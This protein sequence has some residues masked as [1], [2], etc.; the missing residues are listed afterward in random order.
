MK[1]KNY[2]FNCVRFRSSKYYSQVYIRVWFF[3]RRRAHHTYCLV[4]AWWFSRRQKNVGIQ[5]LYM[6]LL[7]WTHCCFKV[8]WGQCRMRVPSQT[9]SPIHGRFD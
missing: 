8:V 2:K 1:M 7:I 4:F 9:Y 3:S 6:V 5:C